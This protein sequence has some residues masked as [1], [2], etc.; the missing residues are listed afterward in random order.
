MV[1]SDLYEKLKEDFP[2]LKNE[3]LKGALD[4]IFDTMIEGLADGKTICIRNFGYLWV[5]QKKMPKSNFKTFTAVGEEKETFDFFRFA[6]SP[7]I[8]EELNK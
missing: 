7:K 1:K 6:A 4:V 5:T 2:H 3:T 8:L